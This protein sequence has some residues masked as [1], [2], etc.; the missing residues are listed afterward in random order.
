MSLQARFQGSQKPATY[1]PDGDTIT[2]EISQY[3]GYAGLVLA[4]GGLD[5]TE[6][7]FFYKNYHFKVKFT[8][9]EEESWPA[10]NSGKMAAS[11]T[12]VDVL[13]AYG[14]QFNVIVPAL[15]SFSRGSDQVV[16]TK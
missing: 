9:S 2:V 10:L 12:T 11:A 13:A 4:N 5:A 7:S 15:I 8:L 16:P 1:H 3:A 14:K 6:N